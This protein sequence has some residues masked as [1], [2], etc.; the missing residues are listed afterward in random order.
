MYKNSKLRSSV[1]LLN[2]P[3]S[4][5]NSNGISDTK[6]WSIFG[7]NLHNNRTPKH[8]DLES[9]KKISDEF[10]FDVPKDP[11]LSPYLTSDSLLQ[12][13]PPV[14]ILVSF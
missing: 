4:G 8:M 6:T 10:E 2:T 14:K 12:R 13:L 5:E 3:K 11:Y 7:W 1:P 9:N